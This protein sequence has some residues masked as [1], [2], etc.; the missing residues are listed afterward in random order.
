VRAA[1]HT[2]LAIFAVH[3]RPA[4]ILIVGRFSVS[5]LAT[6]RPPFVSA[7]TDTP[8]LRRYVRRTPCPVCDWMVRQWLSCALRFSAFFIPPLNVPLSL[9]AK[10]HG[11]SPSGVD[12]PRQV[13][14]FGTPLRLPTRH[15]LFPVARV[16]VYPSRVE[17]GARSRAEL[18]FQFRDFAT[19][20]LF[21]PVLFLEVV[22]FREGVHS[23]PLQC[24]RGRRGRP[25]A[26]VAVPTVRRSPVELWMA[27]CPY[28]P[29]FRSAPSFTRRT[30]LEDPLSTSPRQTP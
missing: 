27:S 19:V 26:S 23:T 4:P 28:T 3:V 14:H 21:Y 8:A 5:N 29:P 2:G 13:R 18:P 16:A 11:R 15:S 24:A 25:R 10:V 1:S 17:R 30:S 6:K 9:R 7:A 20:R 12:N 22:Y